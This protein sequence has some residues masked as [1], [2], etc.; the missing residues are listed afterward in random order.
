LVGVDVSV[1]RTVFSANFPVAHRHD[2]GD[3][4]G[5]MH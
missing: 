2:D 5:A 3:L 4:S 1:L